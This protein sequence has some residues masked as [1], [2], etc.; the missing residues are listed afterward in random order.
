MSALTL[1]SGGKV[2]APGCAWMSAVCEPEDHKR[3]LVC[4]C[5]RHKTGWEETKHWP[6]VESTSERSPFGRTNIILWPRPFGLLNEN[7][8]RAKILWKNYRDM[9][10]SRIPA[11]ATETLHCPGPPD[12]NISTW[13]NDMEGHAKKCVERYCELA[14]KATQQLYKVAT[15]CLDDHQF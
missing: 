14:N 10:G 11:G 9:F 13:A 1:P 12:S 5:G 3:I 7:P 4:E 6:N 2:V 15:P 8:K